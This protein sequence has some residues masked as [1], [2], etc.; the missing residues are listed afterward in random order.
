LAG[1]QRLRDSADAPAFAGSVT[2]FEQHYD[3]PAGVLQPARNVV[4]LELQRLHFT[5][6]LLLF[7][8]DSSYA[9]NRTHLTSPLRC[10]NLRPAFPFPWK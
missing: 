10:L 4:E 3:A 2:A 7:H 5:L 1:I 6:V 8:P 9:A